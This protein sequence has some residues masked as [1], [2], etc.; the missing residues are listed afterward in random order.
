[1]KVFLNLLNETSIN[2]QKKIAVKTQLRLEKWVSKNNNISSQQFHPLNK[3]TIYWVF[4]QNYYH[5]LLFIQ[6]YCS[7]SKVWETGSSNYYHL[8]FQEA[9]GNH[10]PICLWTRKREGEESAFKCY[11]LVCCIPRK[12]LR[13]NKILHRKGV[14]DI[15]I[16]FLFINSL[17][18]FL[19]K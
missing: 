10:P 9:G 13:W 7:T 2:Q 4:Q 3:L 6:W 15:R 16:A 14:V 11:Y 1:M 17:C 18:Y 5:L 12:Q 8:T 19:N